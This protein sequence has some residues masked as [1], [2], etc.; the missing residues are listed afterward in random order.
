MSFSV[1]YIVQTNFL[2]AV[3]TALLVCAGLVLVARHHRAGRLGMFILVL[4]IFI[5]AGSLLPLSSP[6]AIIPSLFLC[7]VSIF[8]YSSRRIFLFFFP[9]LLP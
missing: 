4:I 7:L 3:V 9:Y 5:Q 1:P 8:L 6:Y 2:V